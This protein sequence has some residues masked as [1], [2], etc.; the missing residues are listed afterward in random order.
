MKKIFY[1]IVVATLFL[2]IS[3]TAQNFGINFTMGFPQG[4]LKQNVLREGFGIGGEVL[5]PTMANS[6]V[7]WGFDVAFLNYGN[8][9]R[10]APLSN[11]I[12][13]LTVDVNRSNNIIMAHAL[14]RI[15][16]PKGVFRPYLDLIAGGAYIY[17]Q[18]TLTERFSGTEKLTDENFKDWAFSYGVGAGFMFAIYNEGGT[19]VMIDLKARYL[20]GTQAEYLTEGDIIINTQNA[21]VSYNTRRSK[22]D[23]LLAQIG[24]NIGFDATIK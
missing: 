5:F 20:Y 21:T 10:R 17:T 16:P 18:T 19:R 23:I 11:T 12:P 2:S 13:D 4:E 7:E 9:T 1:S 3:A 6:P 15:A 8:E 22:T 24:V 14:I